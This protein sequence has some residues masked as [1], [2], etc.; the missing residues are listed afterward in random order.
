M[1]SRR[2]RFCW[3]ACRDTLISC[4]DAFSSRTGINPKAGL[5]RKRREGIKC[6]PILVLRIPRPAERSL[7]R[8]SAPR[9]DRHR[10]GHGGHAGLERGHGGLAEGGGYPRP[11]PGPFG[12]AG[13]TR[14]AAIAGR[15]RGRGRRVAVGRLAA[16]V[17]P[18]SQ[19][20]RSLALAQ[21]AFL[22][23]RGHQRAVLLEDHAAGEAASA[24][25]AR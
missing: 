23:D 24:L 18:G 1:R 17:F 7:F 22:G 16:M 9:F 4:S 21:R 25:R 6:Q 14:F 20:L 2:Q 13:C 3:A 8:G 5:A 12:P 19:P 15:Y 11:V 10:H